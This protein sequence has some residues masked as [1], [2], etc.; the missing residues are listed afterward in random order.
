MYTH[1]YIFMPTILSWL[2]SQRKKKCKTN[3]DFG[4]AYRSNIHKLSHI[5]SL[6][7]IKI[8]P[9]SP[10]ILLCFGTSPKDN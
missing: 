7:N 1:I 8:S 10:M 6:H 9:T 2:E 4:M 3:K 5:L